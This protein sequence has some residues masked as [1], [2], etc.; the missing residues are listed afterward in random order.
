MSSRPQCEHCGKYAGLGGCFGECENKSKTIKI[1]L[2]DCS[3]YP[4]LCDSILPNKVDSI[5]DIFTGCYL[6]HT[7]E[8]IR[9]GADKDCVAYFSRYSFKPD[10]ECE[11]VH[12]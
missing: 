6:V 1:N 2:L 5:F 9:I 8:L 12:D 11:V 10:V 3:K 4:I 7:D